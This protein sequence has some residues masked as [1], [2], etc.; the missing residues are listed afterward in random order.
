MQAL[1]KLR[2]QLSG[3]CRHYT[4]SLVMVALITI[5]LIANSMG[6]TP[7]MSRDKVEALCWLFGVV[8]LLNI[9]FEQWK[10]QHGTRPALWAELLA[11]VCMVVGVVQ[12]YSADE[13]VTPEILWFVSAIC[14]VLL[15]IVG[16]PGVGRSN[17]MPSL[18]FSKRFLRHVIVC[19]S[20]GGLACVPV[21]AIFKFSD[22][23]IGISLSGVYY[24]ALTLVFVNVALLF[25]LLNMPRQGRS[26]GE[27]NATSPFADKVLCFVLV[28]GMCIY[29]IVLYLSIVV[30]VLNWRIPYDMTDVVNVMM[31]CLAVL[32]WLAYPYSLRE[33]NKRMGRL[34][35]RVFPMLALPIVF[36]ASV[37]IWQ[38]VNSEG[39]NVS[40]GYDVVLNL[41]FYAV[42]I[43]SL[44]IRG[45]RVNWI[46]ISLAAVLILTGCLPIN[47]SSLVKPAMIS[48]VVELA[49]ENA[50]ATPLQTKEQYSQWLAQ[51]PSA[52]RDELCNRIVA[53]RKDYGKAEISQ[54]LAPD[55]E[56]DYFY[57]YA[58]APKIN[59]VTRSDEAAV[60]PGFD[61]VRRLERT[62][63]R[64]VLMED[65]IRL[66]TIDCGGSNL[67]FLLNY[68]ELSQQECPIVYSIDSIGALSITGLEYSSPSSDEELVEIQGYLFTAFS[69]EPPKDK[70]KQ[71][72]TK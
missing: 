65:S 37:S 23:L 63:L 69:V 8:I 21:W 42:C 38:K 29:F 46:P 1:V 10:I 41:W 2:A 43:G 11:G 31:I 26:E 30:A 68:A 28:P 22:T 53:L 20:I 66:V 45:R 15:L 35:Y 57:N 25:L 51:Y 5:T 62:K 18:N 58:R 34:V 3:M 61:S 54:W 48:R 40:L 9:L 39:F 7:W 36:M 72:Q 44:I 12:L 17:D 59:V 70:Q 56:P 71:T 24:L 13:I 49:G 67:M 32:L 50:P 27:E 19:A 4:E 55:V 64:A 16:L 33:N 6:W 47:L 52:V 60:V 14:G